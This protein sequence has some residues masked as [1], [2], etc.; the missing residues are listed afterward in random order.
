MPSFVRG[1]A[2]NLYTR[3]SMKPNPERFCMAAMS[4][5]VLKRGSLAIADRNRAYAWRSI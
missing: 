2:T 4:V 5:S 3:P 1:I